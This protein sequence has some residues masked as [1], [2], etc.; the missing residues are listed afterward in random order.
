MTPLGK[1]P[2]NARESCAPRNRIGPLLFCIQN[3]Q[4]SA[5]FPDSSYE[6]LRKWDFQNLLVGKVD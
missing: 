5:E 2:A 1:A 3:L 4:S 6:I